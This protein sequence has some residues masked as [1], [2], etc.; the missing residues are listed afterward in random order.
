MHFLCVDPMCWKWWKKPDV[1]LFLFF[2]FFVF[3]NISFIFTEIWENGMVSVDGE[4]T[5]TRFYSL[6][7]FFFSFHWIIFRNLKYTLK[8]FNAT[9][10]FIGFTCYLIS[11]ICYLTYQMHFTL[12]VFTLQFLRFFFLFLFPQLTVSTAKH[13]QVFRHVLFYVLRSDICSLR[14][15]SLTVKTCCLRLLPFFFFLQI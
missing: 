1:F 8:V 3:L 13:K 7:S 14:E 15:F 10:K 11:T 9:T 12:N 6:R 2:V 5:A 4:P